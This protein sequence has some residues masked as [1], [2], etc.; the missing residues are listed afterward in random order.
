MTWVPSREYPTVGRF[1]K[2]VKSYR[3]ERTAVRKLCRRGVTIGGL[4]ELWVRSV[5][6][7]RVV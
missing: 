7:T 2:K 3:S 6:R 1:V 4:S 5:Y